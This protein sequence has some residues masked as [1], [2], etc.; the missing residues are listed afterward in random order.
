MTVITDVFA[1]FRPQDLL[2]IFIVAVIFYR[3]LM[4]IRE[5]RAEQ[6]IKGLIVLLIVLNISEWLEL[7]M[8]RFILQNAMTFGAVALLVVFQPELRRALEYIG[9]SKIYSKSIAE[10]LDEEFNE[11]MDNIADAIA[12]LSQQ[13]IGALVVMEKQTGL[14]DII[15][16]GIR[17]ESKISSELLMNIFMPNAPLHDGAVVIRK[18][19]IMAAGC[20]LP[21]TTSNQLSKELGTRHRAALGMV[22]NSDA[23]V[24]IV[25]EETGAI[26]IAREGKL[27]RFLD[28]QTLKSL[29]SESFEKE[30]DRLIIKRKWWSKNANKN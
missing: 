16:T 19:K 24:I 10:I 8:V 7:Y 15:N 1:N 6:L 22:E 12:Y 26:S 5:T 30:L 28:T 11:N 17:I 3:L 13:K 25:S 2:D 29:I 18:N 27:S 21:L 9:R 20:F 14:S 23:L 4:F